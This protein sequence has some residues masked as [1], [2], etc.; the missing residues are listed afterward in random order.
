MLWNCGVFPFR[1]RFCNCLVECS[2]KVINYFWVF[3]WA[4][5]KALAYERKTCAEPIYAKIKVVTKIQKVS[6]LVALHRGG[7][8]RFCA[9]LK[10]DI[11]ASNSGL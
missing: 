10:T 9:R 4:E 3:D 2:K 11:L 6:N 8:D 7:N 5:R 1:W